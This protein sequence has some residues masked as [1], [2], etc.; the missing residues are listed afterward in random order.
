M[1][2]WQAEIALVKSISDLHAA[3]PRGARAGGAG[4]PPQQ[5]H[6]PL[7]Q[8]MRAPRYPLAR[9]DHH[10]DPARLQ[11]RALSGE[12]GEQYLPLVLGPVTSAPAGGL[13]AATTVVR[14]WRSLLAEIRKRVA[15][16][17][18][19]A[20]D[21]GPDQRALAATTA[22]LAALPPAQFGV[23]LHGQCQDF[24]KHAPGDMAPGVLS[25]DPEKAL[26][27]QE[28]KNTFF[29]PPTNFKFFYPWFHRV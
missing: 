16:Q 28:V 24:L 19:T 18:A 27:V 22:T 1:A 7:R 9:D 21:R 23:L 29:C 3:N 6:G 20:A 11:G 13:G 25:A 14:D 8:P 26:A 2:E 15:A 5:K 17:H 10:S 12:G 4:E